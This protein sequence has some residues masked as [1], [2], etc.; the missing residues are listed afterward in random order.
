MVFR[1]SIIVESFLFE[2]SQLLS[3]HFYAWPSICQFEIVHIHWLDNP[4]TRLTNKHSKV[5]RVPIDLSQI[6]F[7]MSRPARGWPYRFLSRG[8]TGSSILDR[9]LDN[10]CFGGR[11]PIYGHSDFR[12]LE[13]HWGIFH[14]DLDTSG[15][16]INCLSWKSWNLDLMSMTFAVVI[17][18]TDDPCSTNQNH[19]LQRHLGKRP[20]LRTTVPEIPTPISWNDRSPSMSQNELSV[21]IP[22][23][24]DHLFLVKWTKGISDQYPGRTLPHDADGIPHAL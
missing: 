9:D 22:H 23:F 13:W 20:C 12:I 24:F 11:I 15:H 16:C 7:L 2:S 10:L 3:T 4:L 8:T 18:D 17:W 19:L 6:V 14:F 1:P 5:T 21:L